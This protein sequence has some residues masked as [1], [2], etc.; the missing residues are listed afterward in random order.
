MNRFAEIG[1]LIDGC[2]GRQDVLRSSGDGRE[3][4]GA[5]LDEL[6]MS[7]LLTERSGALHWTGSEPPEVLMRLTALRDGPA[8]SLVRVPTDGLCPVTLMAVPDEEIVGWPR[9]TGWGGAAGTGFAPGNATTSCLFEVAERCSQMKDG[10]EEVV[11]AALQD[12]G[13]TAI[14]PQA[15]LHFSHRQILE[16]AAEPLLPEARRSM[17]LPL[18]QRIAWVPAKTIDRNRIRWVPADYCY[19]SSQPSAAAWTCP[20]DSTGCASGTTRDDAIMRGFL[21]AVERDAV[22]IWWFNRL[23]RSACALGVVQHPGIRAVSEW[24]ASIDRRIHLLDLTSDLSVPVVA[25]VSYNKDGRGIAV[26]FGSHFDPSEAAIRAALEMMQFHLM[27]RLS[28]ARRVRAPNARPSRETAS[29]LSWF[30]NMSIEDADYLLPAKGGE[31]G[32]DMA[33]PPDSGLSRCIEIAETHGLDPLYVDLTRP[34]FGIPAVRVMIPG[35]RSIKPRFGLGRLFDVPV[36]MGWRDRA[37]LEEEL[38]PQAFVF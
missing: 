17:A 5:A 26:G 35:L 15:L 22:S 6:E 33:N 24:Q 1:R 20:A 16:A 10:D 13:D 14:S 36:A 32:A 28:L 23:R 11:E 34:H 29:A 3:A 21:E 37:C 27:M 25:A 4:L 19:R 38:N 31:P 2:N 8:R 7:G 12:L 30:L 18:T 9:L